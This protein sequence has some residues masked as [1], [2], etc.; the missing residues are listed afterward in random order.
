MTSLALGLQNR[1]NVLV[2]GYGRGL[3][4][5]S[6]K[7]QSSREAKSEKQTHIFSI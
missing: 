3:T 1:Q 2:K 5:V 7:S 6:G 4:G